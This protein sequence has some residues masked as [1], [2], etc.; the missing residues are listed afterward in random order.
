[1]STGMNRQFTEEQIQSL[2]KYIRRL[3]EFKSGQG[4]SN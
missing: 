2:D 4:Y 3:F 1:M